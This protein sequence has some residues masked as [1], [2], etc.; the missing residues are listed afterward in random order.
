M[1]IEMNF[2]SLN[3]DLLIST[4]TRNI[5]LIVLDITLRTP[6]GALTSPFMNYTTV[7]LS[8][9]GQLNAVL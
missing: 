5:L 2:R 9:D 3:K 4:M 1:H 8:E 6:T 7:S